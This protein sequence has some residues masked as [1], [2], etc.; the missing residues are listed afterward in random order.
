MLNVI[1]ASSILPTLLDVGCG[2]AGLLNY[3][4]SKGFP[5]KY[6]GIDIAANMLNHARKEFPSHCFIEDDILTG[7]LK[8]TYD[9]IVCNG[10][11]TQKLTASDAD[12]EEFLKK[13]I[14]KMFALCKVGV[15]FNV[16][17]DHVNFRVDNLFY[18][19]PGD[20]LAHCLANVTRHIKIDHSYPMYE[21][22][23]Y[24]YKEGW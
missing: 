23:V 10:I 11:L 17:T 21:Y 3:S 8:E 9:Y 20:L 16:M 24:L 13:L 1:L 4:S 7:D 18:K 12:M 2:Y 15:A 22:T 5:I 19:N 14:D 6:T